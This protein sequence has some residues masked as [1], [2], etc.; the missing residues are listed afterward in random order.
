MDDPA[1]VDP[2]YPIANPDF[3]SLSHDPIGTR[4]LRSKVKTRESSLGL[5]VSI[6]HEVPCW[7][8]KSELNLVRN[9][10]SVRS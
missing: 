2:V 3:G 6:F 8:G 10:A 4:L 1:E 9:W 7:S 5:G